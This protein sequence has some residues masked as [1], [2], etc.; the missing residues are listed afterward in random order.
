VLSWSILLHDVAKVLKTSV[1]PATGAVIILRDPIHPFHSAI[2]AATIMA[3]QG[4]SHHSNQLQNVELEEWVALVQSAIIEDPLLSA[5]S[6]SRYST[7]LYP[8]KHDNTVL[9][10][11]LSQLQHLFGTNSMVTDIITLILLHQSITFVHH[12]PAAAPLTD[13]EIITLISPRLLWLLA[14]LHLVDSGSYQL[15]H[16]EVQR[17]YSEEIRQ[18]YHRLEELQTNKSKEEDDG[19][20][21]IQAAVEEEEEIPSQQTD[22]NAASDNSS[23]ETNEIPVQNGV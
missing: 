13:H 4:F 19:V 18:S 21:I 3:R 14:L 20:L 16:P 10:H 1:N 23:T 11:I 5:T 6:P 8:L 2:V 7:S 12:F 15:C 22:T 17:S 9:P